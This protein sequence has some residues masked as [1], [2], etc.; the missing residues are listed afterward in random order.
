MAG[1][2]PELLQRANEE[3]PWNYRAEARTDDRGGTNGAR[4]QYGKVKRINKRQT[5]DAGSD[6]QNSF[7]SCGLFSSS[8]SWATRQAESWVRRRKTGAARRLDLL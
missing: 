6:R 7:V 8:C 4:E 2:F 1:G 3:T 5:V